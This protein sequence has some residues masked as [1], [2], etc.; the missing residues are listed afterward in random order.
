MRARS[1]GARSRAGATREPQ[2]PNRAQSRIARL[3]APLTPAPVARR[4][5]RRSDPGRASPRLVAAAATPPRRRL[6]ASNR[7]R[8]QSNRVPRA[9]KYRL[10]R[11]PTTSIVCVSSLAPPQPAVQQSSLYRRSR[12][13]YRSPFPRDRLMIARRAATLRRSTLFIGCNVRLGRRPER[14]TWAA[15]SSG[16]A[17]CAAPIVA[18]AS[19]PAAP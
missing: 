16:S 13:D 8:P 19:G 18:F 11:A 10:R 3:E 9:P 1:S 6:T 14:L 7:S 4:P 12:C 2:R 15:G 17:P 5:A